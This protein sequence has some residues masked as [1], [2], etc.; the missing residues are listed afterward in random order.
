MNLVGSRI[1]SQAPTS[2]I[3]VGFRLQASLSNEFTMIGEARS[4]RFR[5]ANITR[6]LSIPVTIPTKSRWTTTWVSNVKDLLLSVTEQVR[7][8]Y[9]M[10]F[11]SGLLQRGLGFIRGLRVS[12]CYKNWL[13]ASKHMVLSVK[14]CDKDRLTVTRQLGDFLVQI[15][16][17]GTA[18]EREWV[19]QVLLSW[20]VGVS[21]STTKNEIS[22]LEEGS[23]L[24]LDSRDNDV[25]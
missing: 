21:I 18:Y 3:I 20:G 2:R 15:V 6:H 24:P 4:F 7:T 17:V 22:V 19:G 1:R 12:E 14:G 25:V 16:T 8:T 13:V 11:S 5:L 23:Q 9:E 10:H